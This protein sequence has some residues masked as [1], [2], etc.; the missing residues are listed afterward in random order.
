MRDTQELVIEKVV[1]PV[2]TVGN[3]RRMDSTRKGLN[4]NGAAL[5]LNSG[6]LHPKWEGTYILESHCSNLM[7]L[8]IPTILANAKWCCYY[9]IYSHTSVYTL[10]HTI[11][12]ISTGTST[13]EQ[14]QN[15][16]YKFKVFIDSFKKYFLFIWWDLVISNSVGK[17]PLLLHFSWAVFLIA[18]T[19]FC[20]TCL[21]W[22][23]KDRLSAFPSLTVG[24]TP[25][26]DE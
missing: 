12:S 5:K 16:L 22:A 2:C 6:T 8:D 20:F 3:K 1:E 10:H 13:S 17:F 24:L 19:R 11:K 14:T 9:P 26:N 21:R 7:S 4:Q 25:Q 15:Q 23:A 18:V